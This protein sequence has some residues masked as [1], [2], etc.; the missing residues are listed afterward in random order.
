M[1]SNRSSSMSSVKS[2]Q[3]PTLCTRE[4]ETSII[5]PTKV[6]QRRRVEA[7]PFNDQ[8]NTMRKQARASYMGDWGG[9]HCVE[10]WPEMKSFVVAALIAI[11]APL[12]IQGPDFG[13]VR[14][15][16][17]INLLK[18]ALLAKMG[19]KALGARRGVPPLRPETSHCG[20]SGGKDTREASPQRGRGNSS[21]VRGRSE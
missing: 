1:P 10:Q 14:L 4:S 16:R 6:Q 9:R 2:K 19:T 13:A 12:A 18:K 17:W 8:L 5:Q 11:A 7:T 20:G 3:I 15:A 21:S